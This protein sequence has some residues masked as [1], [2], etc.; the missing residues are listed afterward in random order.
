[1]K[2]ENRRI[3]VTAVGGD[4]GTSVVKCI[5][6]SDMNA[7]VVGCDMIPY[8][9]GREITDHF[10][11]APPVKEEEQYTRFLMDTINTE[12]IDAFL[13]MSDVEINFIN[14]RRE[15]FEACGVELIMNES[16]VIDTFMD[17]YET[18]L[19]FN[20]NNI[21]CPR[22]WLPEDYN[23]QLGFPLILKKRKGSGGLGLFKVTENEELQFYLKRHPGMVIQQYLPGEDNEYT[24][25]IFSDGTKYHTIT[26]KRRLAPGGFSG[27]VELVEDQRITD[28]LGKISAALPFKG[29]INVQFRLVDGVC[30]PFEINPRFSSTVY[31]RHIFGFRDVI[32]S[33]GMSSGNPIH[34]VPQ[35][36][37]GIGVKSFTETLFNMERT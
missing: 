25:C 5:K 33:L 26:F 9:P 19:F 14:K 4:L 31:F 17:K 7:H 37:R 10:L 15:Q 11:Q 20:R 16:K 8:A 2:K 32:W 13:P 22:T 1:M 28:F 34:Y 21:P 35:Y 29:S 6:D 18:A 12:K 24:S 30:M 36:K 27:Y 3:L 23:G